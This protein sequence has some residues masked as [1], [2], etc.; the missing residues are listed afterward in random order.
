MCSMA[1]WSVRP[2][3]PLSIFLPASCKTIWSCPALC[4]S[5]SGSVAP[6]YRSRQSPANPIIARKFLHGSVKLVQASP[7]SDFTMMSA[8][9]SPISGSHASNL[10][11]IHCLVDFLGTSVLPSPLG[12]HERPCFYFNKNSPHW[13]A[14]PDAAAWEWNDSCADGVKIL[15]VSQDVRTSVSAT[16]AL[17][18]AS[19]FLDFKSYLVLTFPWCTWQHHVWRWIVLLIVLRRGVYL[20]IQ[21]LNSHFSKNN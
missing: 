15:A 5:P 21:H 9:T 13:L 10:R 17:A 6:L 20:T 4:G 11:Q 14:S 16:R 8:S 2:Q 3:A 12:D 19:T 7:L 1:T 18:V